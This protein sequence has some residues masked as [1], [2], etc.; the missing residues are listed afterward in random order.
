MKTP[1]DWETKKCLLDFISIEGSHTAN[2]ILNKLTNVLQDFNISDKVI[3][4][5]TDN[6]SNMIACGRELANELEEGFFNLTFYIIDVLPI[7]LTW[8]LKLE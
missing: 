3:S 8:Q 5:T 4:L 1:N 6:G 2:L 7:L